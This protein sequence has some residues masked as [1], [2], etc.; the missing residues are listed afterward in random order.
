MSIITNLEVNPEH[1][2]LA[3]LVMLSVYV[4]LQI[5]SRIWP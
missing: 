2:L 3:L 4:G 1:V 5:G